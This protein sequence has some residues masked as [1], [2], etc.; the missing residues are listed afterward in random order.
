LGVTRINANALI[1]HARSRVADADADAA[2][3]ASATA[4]GGGNDDGDGG[5]V[6]A[7]DAD[8]VDAADDVAANDNVNVDDDAAVATARAAIA[9]L[10][11]GAPLSD[12]DMAM[13]LVDVLSSEK[14][15]FHGY[16]LVSYCSLSQVIL[17]QSFFKQYQHWLCA[18]KSGGLH[19]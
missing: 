16:V 19:R 14:V 17:F 12:S 18:G 15:A 5:V 11:S 2:A 7:P 8:D 10:D 3:A 9:Q 4:G 6:D 13:L 1:E